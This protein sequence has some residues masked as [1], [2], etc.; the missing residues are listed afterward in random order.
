M[1]SRF[2]RQNNYPAQSLE[3]AESFIS[4]RAMPQS[5]QGRMRPLESKPQRVYGA[6]APTNFSEPKLCPLQ[7]NPSKQ[8]TAVTILRYQLDQKAKQAHLDNLK[9]NLERRLQ[10]AK[11]NGNSELVAILNREFKELAS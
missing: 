2:D 1:K 6:I 5:Y 3:I 7:K 10:S 4:D 11:E 8:A 9:R